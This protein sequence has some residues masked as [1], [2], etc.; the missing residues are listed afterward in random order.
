M[1]WWQI[2]IN[3]TIWV[4]GVVVFFVG[5]Y[6][7]IMIP[8]MIVMF[9]IGTVYSSF[10]LFLPFLPDFWET[11]STTASDSPKKGF[12]WG[13]RTEADKYRD[14]VEHIRIQHMNEER[15]RR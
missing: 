2:F 4:I 6:A 14:L 15:N 9:V 3:C 12:D 7:I 8:M 1:D 13:E 5:L 11:V 10:R